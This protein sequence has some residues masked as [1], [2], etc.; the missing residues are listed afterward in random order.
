MIADRDLQAKVITDK[1]G[2]KTAAIF[3][4]EV[5]EECWKTLLF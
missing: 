4:I 1:N 3:P 2:K 5:F